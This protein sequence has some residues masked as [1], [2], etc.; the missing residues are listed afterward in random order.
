M[1]HGIF[2]AAELTWPRPGSLLSAKRR[3]FNGTRLPQPG[4]SELA[5]G[6]AV[7][8][9]I[10]YA[11]GMHPTHAL[12]VE[13]R[14]HPLFGGLDDDQ[15]TR[16]VNTAH[17]EHLEEG[18]LLFA[19]QQQARHFFLV[20]NGSIRL[21][22]STPDGTEKVLH[23]VAPGET[24]AEAITFMDG[25][26]YPVNASALGKSEVIAFSNNTFR[27][28]LRES[29]DTC[30]R[31]MADMSSWLKRQLNDINALTLQNASLRFTNFLLHQAPPG[32]QFDISI[33]LAAP[34]HVIAS[35]LSI[36]PESLSRILRNM[37]NEGLVRVEGNIIHIPDI[38][39]IDTQCPSQ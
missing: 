31:L 6:H 15:M 26:C 13:L 25:Q 23:L 35:R 3:E 16:L 30:F 4:P 34:K 14:R 24:F 8:H 5:P 20:R 19:S 11:T 39:L 36:Q 18:Q 37:Q 9:Q 7:L 21:Y 27:D 33:E 1:R 17:L 38:K 29:T 2:P 22:L 28:I 10:Q 12:Q 32:Q